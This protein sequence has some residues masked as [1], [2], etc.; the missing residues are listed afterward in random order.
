MNFLTSTLVLVALT[1]LLFWLMWR[2]WRR[3]GKRDADLAPI[4]TALTGDTIASFDRVFYVATT[5]Q[6]APLERVAV[7]GLAFRGWAQ[8][9]V[10][11]DGLEVQVTG[12]APV[13]IAREAITGETLA[14]LTIDKVVEHDGLSNLE[15][16]SPRGTLATSFRFSTPNQQHEFAESI[17][18]MLN[19]HPNSTP[20]RSLE[21][22]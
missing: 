12:E 6:G 3:R 2:S 22:A 17:A 10:R 5:P 8:V 18:R 7:P 1:A 21:E 4:E 16:V 19:Q 13:V 20:A 11:T 15:W 9:A 14:Q